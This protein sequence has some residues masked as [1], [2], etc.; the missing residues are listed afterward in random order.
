MPVYAHEPNKALISRI[1]HESCMDNFCEVAFAMIWPSGNPRPLGN[2][3]RNVSDL[4]H[5]FIIYFKFDELQRGHA[6]ADDHDA[7]ERASDGA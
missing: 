6:K 4:S 2:G 3:F 5:K 1:S 7:L